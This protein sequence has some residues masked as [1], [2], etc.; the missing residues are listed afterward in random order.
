MSSVLLL[1]TRR[2]VRVEA[3]FTIDRTD[4]GVN[5]F[6]WSGGNLSIRK[7]ITIHLALGCVRD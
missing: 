3:T 7:E 4:Y 2:N 1:L 6:R 5:G